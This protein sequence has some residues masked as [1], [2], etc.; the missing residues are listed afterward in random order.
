MLQTGATVMTALERLLHKSQPCPTWNLGHSPA[1]REVART[2]LVICPPRRPETGRRCR[3]VQ[4]E[5]RG[6]RKCIWLPFLLNRVLEFLAWH[7]LYLVPPK[8]ARPEPGGRSGFWR[9]SGRAVDRSKGLGRQPC[10]ARKRHAEN[11]A[12]RRGQGRQR[13][14]PPP[15]TARA[16]QRSG[17][18]EGGRRGWE[19]AFGQLWKCGR[20]R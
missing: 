11:P 8:H 10:A 12:S 7:C 18:G 13:I 14:V 15:S 20:V 2:L 17:S 5:Q 4:G 9:R 16:P 19:S 6:S 1:Q 3:V